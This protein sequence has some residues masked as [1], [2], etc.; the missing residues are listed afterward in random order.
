LGERARWQRQTALE[1]ARDLFLAHGYAATTVESIASAA[2]VSV[3][4]VY[5]TYGGKSGLVRELC[6]QA[7]AGVGPVPAEDRSDALRAVDGPRTLV[8]GWGALIEE[9]SPR[10]SPLLLLLRAAA[11]TDP[12]AAVLYAELDQAR[13]DRMSE[14]ARHLAGRGRLRAGVSARKEGTRRPVAV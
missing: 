5:K 4:T 14:N 12:D 8:E 10:V 9:V 11:E 1:R 3:A 6:T 2:G 13:L 7:L